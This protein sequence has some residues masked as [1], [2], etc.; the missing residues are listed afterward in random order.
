[1]KSN[2]LKLQDLYKDINFTIYI[3]SGKRFQPEP[4]SKMTLRKINFVQTF[5]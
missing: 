3:C 4:F 5:D 2:L 1:M